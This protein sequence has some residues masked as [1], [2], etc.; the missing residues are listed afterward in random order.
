MPIDTLEI[1]DQLKK[2]GFTP[3]QAEASARVF[4]GIASTD[5]ATKRDVDDLKIAV[6]RDL[7]E[8]KIAVKRDLDE[9][10][11]AAKRDLDDLEIGLL[12]K[13]DRQHAELKLWFIGTALALAG[14]TA[15][16]VRLFSP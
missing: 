2:A 15:A 10:K 1:A 4:M 12:S 16:A 14:F 11:I 13:M 9:L 8:L 3:Q 6:K 5:L 7:D